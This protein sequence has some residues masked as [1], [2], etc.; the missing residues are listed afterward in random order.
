MYAVISDFVSINILETVSRKSLFVMNSRTNIQCVEGQVITPGG[1]LGLYS[2]VW[3]K[4]SHYSSA[5]CFEEKLLPWYV[6]EALSPFG[7]PVD[8]AVIA[9]TFY[10]DASSYH[11]IIL[12]SAAS[13]SRTVW[14][15]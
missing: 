8:R 11:A 4:K 6:S 2:V 15:Q 13:T 3:H 7:H 9:L 14:K 12:E 1:K 10:R 5:I